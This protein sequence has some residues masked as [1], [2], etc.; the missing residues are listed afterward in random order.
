MAA[1]SLL[2][3]GELCL[4][5]QNSQFS[6]GQ[7]LSLAG[8]ST[9]SS[10]VF[11]AGAAPNGN[12]IETV[13]TASGAFCLD[14]YNSGSAAGTAVTLYTCGSG[15]NQKWAVDSAGRLVPQHAPTM[16]LDSET[17]AVA[18]GVRLVINPCSD[19]P[20]QKFAAAA[21]GECYCRWLIARHKPHAA[22]CAA[23]AWLLCWKIHSWYRKGR[24]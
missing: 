24:E 8:C 11:R 18:V 1:P 9:I 13:N 20:S 10:Q 7:R 23:L 19:A 12:R 4:Q 15:N 21:A 3:V 22:W 5:V 2:Q 16:C 14:V 6:K 17:G